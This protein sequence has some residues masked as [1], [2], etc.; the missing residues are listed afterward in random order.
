MAK[1][2]LKIGQVYKSKD[3][4]KSNYIQISTTLTAPVT[5]NPGQYL[6]VESKK[7]Q[8]ESLA[9]ALS[10]GIITPENAEK[11]EERIQKIPDWVLG[12]VIVLTE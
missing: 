3:A 10:R 6:Q 11:A 4:T 7:Y 9:G 5:L 1:K 2:R 8:L 12:E